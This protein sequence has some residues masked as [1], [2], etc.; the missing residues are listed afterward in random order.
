MTNSESD[1]G[2]A[3]NATVDQV[4]LFL[5]SGDEAG[6]LRG[7][8][9][10][11]DHELYM[12]LGRQTH[13]LRAE[14]ARAEARL[15]SLGA[16][17]SALQLAIAVIVMVL[18]LLITLRPYLDVGPDMP[19]PALREVPALVTLVSGA[20]VIIAA[21]F[22]VILFAELHGLRRQS[23]EARFVIHDGRYNLKTSE[24]LLAAMAGTPGR[25]RP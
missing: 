6:R 15:R 3:G 23:R 19:G 8:Q 21:V 22:A 4:A 11:S 16:G 10:L 9:G 7:I 2:T 5:G 17:W 1:P 24:A 18:A 12:L 25:D 13:A 14:I 20:V